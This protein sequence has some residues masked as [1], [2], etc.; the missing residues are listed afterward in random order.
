MNLS[1]K[2]MRPIVVLTLLF[3]IAVAPCAVKPAAAAEGPIK[4]GLLL[5]FT[6][7]FAL[8]AQD[9]REGTLLYLDKIGN[10]IAGRKIEVIAEDTEA[11]GDVALTKARKLVE[12]DKVQILA[13]LISSACGYAVAP[14]ADEKK[15]FLIVTGMCGAEGLT[16]NP[17]LRSPY[18]WRT[19]HATGMLTFPVTEYLMKH[20]MKRVVLLMSGYAGGYEV[21]DGFAHSFIDAGGTIIQ[22]IYPALGTTDFG[23]FMA[24]IKQDADAVVGFVVGTDGLRFVQQYAEYGLKGKLPLIDV[25]EE[26]AGVPNLPQLKDAALGILT[27]ISYA[28]DSDTPENRDFLQRV[29]A[30]YPEK[31]RM[32]SSVMAYGYAGMNVIAAALGDVNGKVEDTQKFRAALKGMHIKTAKGS[33]RFD[34]Y[35]NVV[36]DFYIKRV[37]KKEG[38]YV[39]KTIFKVPEV[40][41]FWKWKPAEVLHYPFGR[42]HGKYTNINKAQLQ[43]LIKSATQ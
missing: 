23:P 11:K 4:I 18:I 1:S 14:Y 9:N 38:K 35:Q 21:A 15:T 6:G 33:F 8:V 31:D 37:E 28:Q 7:P 13:G 40:S 32:P 25:S 22:E 36:E 16:K 29:E 19:T 10:A 2:I 34:A 41:E 24:Q 12:K 17:K 3:V 26:M 27:S 43:A 5:P 39:Y 42:L 30:K 20:N